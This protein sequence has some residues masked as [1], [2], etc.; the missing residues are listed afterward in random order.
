MGLGG[1]AEPEIS[2]RRAG[3]DMIG[4]RE[5]CVRFG[6]SWRIDAWYARMAYPDFDIARARE[7]YQSFRLARRGT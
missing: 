4:Y 5:L 7:Y 1:A 6:G 2:S 3:G